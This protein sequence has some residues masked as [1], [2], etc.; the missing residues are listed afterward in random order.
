MKYYGFSKAKADKIPRKTLRGWRNI[1]YSYSIRTVESAFRKEH[2][3]TKISL[4]VLAS[5]GRYYV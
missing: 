5:K 4:R 3:Q 1:V 2:S